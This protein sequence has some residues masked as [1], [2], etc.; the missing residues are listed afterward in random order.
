M[1]VINGAIIIGRVNIE[2]VFSVRACRL[3]IITV[4]SITAAR[5]IFII[6]SVS[7]FYTVGVVTNT[8]DSIFIVIIFIIIIVL[9]LAINIPAIKRFKVILVAA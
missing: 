8:R 2:A 1:L 7:S 4:M 5:I 3:V 9:I 6:I